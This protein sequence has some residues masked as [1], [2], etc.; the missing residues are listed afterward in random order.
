[1]RPTCD[2]IRE[3]DGRHFTRDHQAGAAAGRSTGVAS[4]ER[5]SV[6]GMAHDQKA[7]ASGRGM[8]ALALETVIAAAVAAELKTL[9]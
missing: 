3:S 9:S 4:G 7:R 5:S 2:L 1:V 8:A 6:A